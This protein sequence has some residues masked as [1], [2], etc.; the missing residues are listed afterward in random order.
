VR[1]GTADGRGQR[2]GRV[3]RAR[4]ES[5]RGSAARCAVLSRCMLTLRSC[6]ARAQQRKRSASSCLC[7]LIRPAW[8]APPMTTRLDSQ[9]RSVGPWYLKETTRQACVRASRQLAPQVHDVRPWGAGWG[10]WIGVV[11]GQKQAVRTSHQRGAAG[12]QRR[13][14]VAVLRLR[15]VPEQR[16]M[17]PRGTHPAPAPALRRPADAEHERSMS[18][19]ATAAL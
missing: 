19:A 13:R 9:R 17:A 3:D 2:D 7:P 4:C 18:L 12:A 15:A 14:S 8:P 5:A 16:T 1:C 6:A 10:R 11:W